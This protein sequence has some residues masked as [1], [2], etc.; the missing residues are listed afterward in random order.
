M[1][2]AAFSGSATSPTWVCT[3]LCW[4]ACSWCH[5]STA[6]GSTSTTATLASCSRN[7]PEMAWPMPLTPPVTSTLCVAD[8]TRLLLHRSK[9][10]TADEMPLPNEG[11]QRDRHDDDY[12][13]RRHLP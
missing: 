11:K 7:R 13:N 5:R 1:M 4:L 6:L 12:A 8:A 10:Q 3:L 9:G 2:I